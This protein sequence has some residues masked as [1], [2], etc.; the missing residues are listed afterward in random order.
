MSSTNKLWNESTEGKKK[1]AE[2]EAM[3]NIGQPLDGQGAV[4]GGDGPTADSAQTGEGSPGTE[5]EAPKHWMHIHLLTF[6]LFGPLSSQDDAHLSLTSSDGPTWKVSTAAPL[7]QQGGLVHP[8]CIKLLAPPNTKLSRR[9]IQKAQKAATKMEEEGGGTPK[10]V[11]VLQRQHNERQEENKAKL[12][13]QNNL[14]KRLQAQVALAIDTGDDE[15]LAA[16]RKKLK[17]ALT[18][19]VELEEAPDPLLEDYEAALSVSAFET[20]E[21]TPTSPDPMAATSPAIGTVSAPNAESIDRTDIATTSWGGVPGSPKKP[22]RLAV[23][24][25]GS[26]P[27]MG[28]D[29]CPRSPVFGDGGYNF[30]GGHDWAEACP[31]SLGFDGGSYSVWG[32]HGWADACPRSPG[33]DD[34]RYSPRLR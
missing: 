24:G 29:A 25:S 11:D 7:P 33:F 2:S 5:G 26:P 21:A 8:D 31:R 20:T 9:E 10:V 23:V 13:T 22:A 6:A 15:E 30:R 32:E 28:A 17:V 18:A 12:E 34:G 16:V 4:A 14:I 3:G 19:G 1:A 27:G